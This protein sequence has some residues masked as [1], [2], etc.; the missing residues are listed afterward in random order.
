MYKES[1]LTLIEINS[2]KT[3]IKSCNATIADHQERLRLFKEKIENCAQKISETEQELSLTQKDRV[4]LENDYSKLESNLEK[5]KK[6]LELATNEQQIKACEKELDTL[7]TEIS[8]TEE[9][10]FSAMELE[11]QH[12]DMIKQKGEEKQGLETGLLE[13]EKE[14]TDDIASE[15]KILEGYQERVEGLES[16]L[17]ASILSTYQNLTKTFAIPFTIINN[18]NCTECGMSVPANVEQQVNT[19]KALEFC[20]SCGRLFLVR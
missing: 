11:E 9:K 18:G 1:F 6:H 15:G 17:P 13:I 4:S 7:T 19:C 20:S 10:V 2:I 14:V 3:Q 5:T 12:Q 8:S 16:Q